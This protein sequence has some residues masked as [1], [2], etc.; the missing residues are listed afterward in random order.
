MDKCCICGKE[1]KFNQTVRSV[2]VKENR[3]YCLECLAIHI[4]PYDDLVNFGW[5]YSW[6]NKSY[7]DKVV[8]PS[9]YYYNKDI[10]QF[11]SDVEKLKEDKENG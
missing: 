8:N 6:F 4:E 2:L 3:T 1:D 7:R 5:E 10:K 9:L 11:N